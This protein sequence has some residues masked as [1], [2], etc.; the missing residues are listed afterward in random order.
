MIEVYGPE[1]G[2]ERTEEGDKWTVNEA[3]DDDI[4][5]NFA[6][7]RMNRASPDGGAW[8]G[9][10]ADVTAPRGPTELT[11]EDATTFGAETD[12]DSME[13][14]ERPPRPYHLRVR[15]DEELDGQA[16]ID[17]E[18]GR[19]TVRYPLRS[20]QQQMDEDEIETQVNPQSEDDEVV[21]E[22]PELFN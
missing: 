21:E 12:N 14:S 20:P 7:P 3:I 11:D 1:Y 5:E 2:I 16:V 15:T 10:Q 17:V 6:F 19:A 8:A 13:E 22:E 18:M 9:M 4:I